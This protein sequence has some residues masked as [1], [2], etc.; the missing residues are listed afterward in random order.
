MVS[1]AKEKP[2]FPSDYQ[3]LN[4]THTNILNLA[5]NLLGI[6]GTT[7][8]ELR[9]IS[10]EL[11]ISPG[12]I[13]H[14]YISSEELIFDTV[15]F[16]YSNLVQGILTEIENLQDSEAVL[17][18][19]IRSMLDW[20]TTKPGIGVILEFPRQVLRTGSKSATNAEQMLSTF[21]KEISEIGTKNVA[22]VASAV[23]G[24]QK[25]TKFKMLSPAKVAGLIAT[26]SKFATYTSMAGFA[27]IGAG[28]WIAGRRPSDRKNSIWVKLGFDPAKQT[29]TVIN[30]FVKMIKDSN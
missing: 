9:E 25:N 13:H 30:N 17:R 23:R 28:L 1:L 7:G 4:A 14:Y 15:L 2:A 18:I 20:E 10:K 5:E 19:W 11:Q 22:T 3:N 8:F 27:T 6:N 21:L 12:L 29:Q 16:S 26:D 24:I